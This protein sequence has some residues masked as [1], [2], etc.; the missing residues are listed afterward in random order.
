VRSQNQQYQYENEERNKTNAY[1]QHGSRPHLNEH[2]VSTSSYNPPHTED[3]RKMF[4][5]TPAGK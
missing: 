4:A 2:D 5:K 3:Y 1:Q